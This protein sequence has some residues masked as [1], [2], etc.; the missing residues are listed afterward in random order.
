MLAIG[1]I[2]TFHAAHMLPNHTEECNNLHGHTYK[3]EIVI[4]GLVCQNENS[5]SYGMI[6]DFSDLKYVVEEKIIRK[7]DHSFLNNFVENPTAENLLLKICEVLYP[8]FRE[9]I[10]LE[11]VRL[12]ETETSYAEWTR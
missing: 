12:W 3:L 1:K 7:Y 11:K 6:I 5:S 8:Y 2:F 4:S 10:K 9:N